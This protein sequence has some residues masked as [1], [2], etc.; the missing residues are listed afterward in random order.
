MKL[1]LSGE[2][3]GRLTVISFSHKDK[4]TKTYW[5]C[6]CECGNEFTVRCSSLKCNITKSC[7]CLQKQNAGP[8]PIH[9]LHKSSIYRIWQSM[10]QRC[11]NPN[12]DRFKGY[13][14]RGITV[15]NKWLKFVGFYEDMGDRPEG[16]TL[17]RKDNDGNYCKDNCKWSTSKEQQNNMRSNVN[18]IYNGKTQTLSQWARELNIKIGTLNSRI[19]RDKWSVERAFTEPVKHYEGREVTNESAMSLP[20]V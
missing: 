8:K 18:I 3:F 13:M 9:N 20:S 12:N 10:V 7:G 11:T 16:M 17:D 4:Y 14:G 1:D 5:R 19:F 6:K 2:K 15:C